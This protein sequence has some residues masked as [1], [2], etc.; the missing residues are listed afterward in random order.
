MS[1]GHI[2]I[3][4]I[5]IQENLLSI[6]RNSKSLWPLHMLYHYQVCLTEAP[7]WVLYSWQPWWRSLEEVGLLPPALTLGLWFPF[8]S[9]LQKFILHRHSQKDW[10]LPLPSLHSLS[11]STILCAGWEYGG[12]EFFHPGLLKVWVF[13]SRRKTKKNKENQGLPPCPSAHS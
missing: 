11:R 5:L 3:E 8:N 6:S 4:K 1:K 10:S 12:P 2:A 7:P 9:V 13:H